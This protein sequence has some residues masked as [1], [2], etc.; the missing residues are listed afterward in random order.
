MRRNPRTALTRVAFILTATGLA[1]VMAPAVSGAVSRAGSPSATALDD[2]SARSG[3]QIDSVDSRGTGKPLTAKAIAAMRAIPGVQDVRPAAQFGISIVGAAGSSP[4]GAFWATPRT[5]WI[6]PRV[7]TT[8]PGIPPEHLP[9]DDEIYLPDSHGGA[10]T[11]ALLGKHLT[12]QYTKATG[13]SRGEA[14]ETTV[15]VIGLF[16]NSTPGADGE[17]AIYISDSLFRTLLSA[18]LGLA[19]GSSVPDRYA[20]PTVYVKASSTRDV[21]RVQAALARMGFNARGRAAGVHEILG[22]LLLVFCLGG[23]LT[24]LLRFGLRSTRLGPALSTRPTTSSTI[25]GEAGEAR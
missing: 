21:A 3:L 6:Q 15:R 20:Y 8:V 7:T 9:V 22:A 16:D 2:G 1:A 11:A 23:C 5:P 24:A 14:A 18:Q 10:T 17:S 4:A 25:T 13:P 12:I 19:R